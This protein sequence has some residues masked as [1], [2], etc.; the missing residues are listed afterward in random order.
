L[1]CKGRRPL[2]LLIERTSN[3]GKCGFEE[4]Q[5]LLKIVYNTLSSRLSFGFL[6]PYCTKKIF[7][8]K[9]GKKMAKNLDKI[10]KKNSKKQNLG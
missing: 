4:S 1:K 2:F 9:N 10:A 5:R 8:L 7:W 3:E 6:V